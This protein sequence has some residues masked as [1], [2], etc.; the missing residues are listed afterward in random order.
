MPRWLSRTVLFTCLIALVAYAY[1]PLVKAGFLGRD[2]APLVAAS[3]LAWPHDFAREGDGTAALLWAQGGEQRP[4]ASLSLALSSR[5]WT[6]RGTW[7]QTALVAARAENLIVLCLAAGALALCVRRALVPWL[8]SDGAGSAAGSCALVL[9]CHPL[10]V[11]AVFHPGARGD[12]WAA[13]L[14]CAAAVLFLR[15][16]QEREP[17]PVVA[18]AACALLCGFAADLA[19][20]LPAALAALELASARRYRALHV[21]VRTS[22]TTFVVFTACIAVERFAAAAFR[23][24]LSPTDP[25]HDLSSLSSATA[26]ERTAAKLACLVLPV[27]PT[28][29]GVTG[30]VLAGAMMLVALHP[31]LVAARSAPRMWA[32]LGLA[33]C[34]TLFVF[35][36]RRASAA[37]G[38]HDFSNALVLFPGAIAMSAA[39]GVSSSALSGWRRGLL[40]MFVAACAAVLAH[41]A[42]TAFPPAASA[43]GAL[44]G[45]LLQARLLHGNDA[46]LLVIDPP[47]RAADLEILG[48][49]VP[50]LLDPALPDDEGFPADGPRRP[51]PRSWVRPIAL[52][53]LFALVREPEFVEMRRSKLVLVFPEKLIRPDDSSDPKRLSLGLSEPDPV[54]QKIFW[55]QNARSALLDFDPL[56]SCSVR[57]IALPT[58]S[59]AEA[60]ELSWRASSESLEFGARRGV[61]LKGVEGPVAIFDLSRSF[62]W[63]CG[64]RIR[65]LSIQ[66]ASTDL[67]ST[68][69]LEDAPL[70]RDAVEMRV[71]GGD[72]IMSV[73]AGTAPVP[74]AGEG[75]WVLD[76]LDLEQYAFLEIQAAPTPTGEV[77]FPG[78]A[79]WERRVLRARAG[80]L[81]WT[82]A[83]R[84]GETD[85]LRRRGR[86]P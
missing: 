1:A 16:R 37:V 71:H 56:A 54:R 2:V 67:V 68:E 49:A 34:A 8:G 7:S 75:G 48:D 38:P 57:V 29:T 63:M 10:C 81:A 30:F 55:R 50:L 60:P 44:R 27:S 32:A 85:V 70:W 6:E 33:W 31:A 84:V 5:L 65:R 13:M 28:W 21:R 36:F 73:P 4:L 61:W 47:Q 24:P 64:Q 12:L 9:A 62:A 51:P 78:A 53:A 69:V 58:V 25:W 39:L 19:W 83:Y 46:K 15:G 35:A 77:L 20:F 18:A 66:Q 43:L 72:W 40:P 79:A 22:A 80:P 59:T 76:L 17:A 45:D 26:W 14:G 74:L 3:R 11:W 82:L 42:A 86:K 41:S 23:A 52:R